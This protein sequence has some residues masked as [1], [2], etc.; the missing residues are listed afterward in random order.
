M[1]SGGPV[2]FFVL[3]ILVLFGCFLHVD[4]GVLSL[5]EGRRERSVLSR[6]QGRKVLV[7]FGKSGKRLSLLSLSSSFPL[8]NSRQFRQRI[9]GV[10]G[11]PWV[12][13]PFG[14]RFSPRLSLKFDRCELI[15]S[16]PCEGVF[17]PL[18]ADICS[19][20]LCGSGR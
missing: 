15:L 20:S 13:Y 6:W 9:S 2:F 4:V 8:L 14:L 3:L 1:V 11:W 19:V 16:I 18:T 5:A 12:L 17:V 7:D 10:L